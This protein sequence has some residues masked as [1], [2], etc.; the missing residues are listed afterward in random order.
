MEWDEPSSAVAVSRLGH[1]IKRAEQALIREKTRALRDVGLSVPQYTVLLTLADSPGL[2]GAQLAR[3]CMVTPQSMASLL[4]TL[5]AKGLVVREQSDVHA[6]VFQC[7]LTPSG[8]TLLHRADTVALAVEQRLT[9]VFTPAESE[10]FRSLLERTVAILDD[11]TGRSTPATSAAPATPAAPLTPAVPP[12][13]ATSPIPTASPV[14]A[15]SPTPA[16]APTPTVLPTPGVPSTPAA[17]AH[18][19]QAAGQ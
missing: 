10:E 19:S 17:A 14:P 6:K 4:L 16:A 1:S 5:E 7:R 2:S 12:T 11:E 15:A 18:W 9:A 8:R 3:R 13:P